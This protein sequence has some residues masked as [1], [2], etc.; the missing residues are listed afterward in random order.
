MIFLQSNAEKPQKSLQKQSET[1]VSR[2]NLFDHTPAE[3]AA[4]SVA[5]SGNDGWQTVSSSKNKRSKRK[6]KVI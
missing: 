2:A 6:S 1:S 5:T 3:N 4:L